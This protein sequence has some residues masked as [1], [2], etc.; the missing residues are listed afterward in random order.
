MVR[1]TLVRDSTSRRI[2]TAPKNSSEKESLT[3]KS[4]Q[5]VGIE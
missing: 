2:P 3:K 1:R 5:A 4:P